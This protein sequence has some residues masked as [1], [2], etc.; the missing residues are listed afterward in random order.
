MGLMPTCPTCRAH[1]PDDVMHCTLD[2]A[3]LLPDEACAN[4]DGELRAGEL[5]GEYRVEAKIGEGGFGKVYSAVHPV[6]GKRAA[7]KVLN[8]EYS[9]NP[10]VVSRFVSEARAVNQIRHRN[11]IDIFSFGTLRGGLQYFVMELLDGMPLDSYLKNKGA[12]SLGEA[13]P[14]LQAV[15][16]ALDAAHAAGIAHRDLKPENVFLCVDDEG[17]VYPKLLDFGIAKLMGDAAVN[18]KTRTGAAMGTPLYMSPEQCQGKGVDHRT[19]L[20]SFGV[21][22]HEALTG[23][24][25]FDGD[26]M[27]DLMVKHSTEPPPRM[28]ACNATLPPSC[29]APVLAL[30]AKAPA[31]RPASATAAVNALIDAAVAAGVDVAIKRVVTL[32]G[33]GGRAAPGAVTGAPTP[34]TR[35]GATPG[36]APASTVA[37][38]ET[39]VQPAATQ[40]TVEKPAGGAASR[41]WLVAGLALVAGVGVTVLLT[42]SGGDAP[43]SHAASAAPSD[44]GAPSSA[45]PDVGARASSAPAAPSSAAPSSAAPSS[46]APSSAAASSAAPSSAPVAPPQPAPAAPKGAASTLPKPVVPNDLASPWEQK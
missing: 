14:V 9:S 5:V 34:Q 6:I 18:H 10:A 39:L 24:R 20:Y 41:T 1:Y 32:D 3:L 2:G 4:F 31:E 42:R 35:P 36:V 19:D 12:L 30:L 33:I 26:S 44:P 27:M 16:K 40:L 17:G 37:S 46:A 25:P 7:I 43:A 29:D 23:A 21:M 22:I 15:A 11:I 13:L 45:S 38:A 28:S 8:R